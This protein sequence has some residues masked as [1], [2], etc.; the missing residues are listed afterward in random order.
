MALKVCR[1][2]IGEDN[3][4]YRKILKSKIF[5]LFR[6]KGNFKLNEMV[7]I[8]FDQYSVYLISENFAMVYLRSSKRR[9]GA[10]LWGL[11]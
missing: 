10:L 11:F 5:Y 2:G 9:F 1:T 8:I 4:V 7:D 6:K 3:A